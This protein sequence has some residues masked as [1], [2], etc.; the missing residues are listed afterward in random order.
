MKN[1]TITDVR[2]L[3][4]DSGFLLDDGT[5]A[6]LY[7]SGFG[8]TGYA[9]ADKIAAVLGQRPLDYIFLTHSHY[10]HALGSPYICA[11]YPGAKVVAGKY[12]KQI[13]DKPSARQRIRDM[14]RKFARRCGIEDYEDRTDQLRVDIPVEDGD[15]IRAGT[16]EFTVVELPGHT[17]CSVGYYLAAEKLLL[18]AE[19][20][21]VYDGGETVVPSYLVGYAMT[22]DTIGKAEKM[23]IDQILL[24]HFGLLDREQTRFYLK[25]CRKTAVE[26]A[27]ALTAILEQGGSREDA[28]AHFRRTFYR[29]G[30][31][32]IY[33]EDAMELNTNIMV[34]LLEREL[35]VKAAE[36]HIY[37]QKT[38]V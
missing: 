38:P 1:I 4:G 24:P 29:G 37:Q 12:A 23:D 13:F 15:V 25:T 22:L 33:P 9:V 3:P 2:A 26:T 34:S 36:N 8:F 21:G 32:A 30:L 19:T 20:L 35:L 17:K 7:D 16:M 6:V 18:S 10:D 31:P 14:D 27:R 5:T 11:R 28:A